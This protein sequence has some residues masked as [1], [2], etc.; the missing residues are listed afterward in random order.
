MDTA[1]EFGMYMTD[2][3][4]PYYD[5]GSQIIIDCEWKD[6]PNKIEIYEE[7]VKYLIRLTNRLFFLSDD[8]LKKINELIS[9]ISVDRLKIAAIKIN[10]RSYRLIDWINKMDLMIPDGYTY[11]GDMLF[12]GLVTELNN[13]VSKD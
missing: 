11:N 5:D 13:F 6:L 9:K 7:R 4:I 8:K 3:E 1:N 12:S 10:P 2:S